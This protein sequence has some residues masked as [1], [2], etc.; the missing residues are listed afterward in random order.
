M[1]SRMNVLPF[2]YIFN[3]DIERYQKI[4]RKNLESVNLN[5]RH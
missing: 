5:F 3:I 2:R 4:V 1:L